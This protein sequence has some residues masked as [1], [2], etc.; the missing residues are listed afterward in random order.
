VKQEL[1]VP[2]DQSL[3]NGHLSLLELLLGITSSGVRQ[4]DSVADLYVI[5]EGDVLHF[6]TIIHIFKSTQRIPVDTIEVGR[7][8]VSPI[9]RKV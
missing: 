7:T 9:C 5:R 4:V 8:L 3:N 6:D 1:C 2:V